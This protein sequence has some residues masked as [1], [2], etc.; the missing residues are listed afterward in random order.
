MIKIAPGLTGAIF[1]SKEKMK[2][3][4]AMV[5]ISS[6]LLLAVLII[7]L[8]IYT[9]ARTSRG[10]TDFDT[11]HYAAERVVKGMPLYKEIAGVSPYIYPPFFACILAPLAVFNMKA[12]SFMWYL[13]NIIFFSLSLVFVYRIAFGSK[14]VR[15]KWQEERLL[16][17]ALLLIVVFAVFLDNISL[18]QANILIFFAL[19]G[20]LYFFSKKKNIVAASLL[21]TAISIKIMPVLILAYFLLKRKWKFSL[22]TIVFTAL[23]TL[24]FPAL[25]MGF[26]EAYDSLS[27]WW[28]DVFVRS[29]GNIPTFQTMA[30]MFNPVNQ[31]V[32]ASLSR[33]LTENDSAILHWKNIRYH[34]NPFLVDWT[35]G[36]SRQVALNISR[37]AAIILT[38][39]TFLFCIPRR[40][41]DDPALLYYEYSLVLVA[42]LAASPIFRIQYFIFTLLPLCLIFGFFK[43]APRTK[44]LFYTGFIIFSVL[45]FSQSFKICRIFSLGMFALILLW[46]LLAVGLNMRVKDSY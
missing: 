32:T 46:A 43:S 34:Y 18:L 29:S 33:W 7:S 35:A 45:Y 1:Y 14:K 22:V 42:S 27:W 44:N 40:K 19:S 28:K 9:T 6:A 11:Y 13:L 41:E 38:G 2:K 16:P 15:D 12:A 3:Q 24:V 25:S 39:I 26:T 20:T 36:L 8:G 5:K 10:S 23:F 37:L 30:A 31:S 4:P 21:A 17:K